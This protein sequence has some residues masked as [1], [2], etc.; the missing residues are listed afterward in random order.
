M[1]G[2]GTKKKKKRTRFTSSTSTSSVLTGT[3]KS[4]MTLRVSYREKPE[5]YLDLLAKISS[6]DLAM[7]KIVGQRSTLSNIQM[8]R[9]PMMLL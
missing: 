9:K 5:L 2:T 6:I 8:T 1:R 4:T 3:V 7:I